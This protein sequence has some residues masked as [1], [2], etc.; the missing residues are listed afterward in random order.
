MRRLLAWFNDA[1]FAKRRILYLVREHG[2]EELPL[3]VLCP[4]GCSHIGKD[5]P[6]LEYIGKDSVR[7]DVIVPDSFI[8]KCE[9]PFHGKTPPMPGEPAASARRMW[10]KGADDEV[11]LGIIDDTQVGIFV[12]DT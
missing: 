6:L 2:A 11:T 8:G 4:F 12:Y 10:R 3:G 9:V 5:F 1:F 7:A